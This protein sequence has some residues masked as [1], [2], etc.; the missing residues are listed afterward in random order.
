[1]LWIA[2][3]DIVW[4]LKPAFSRWRTFHWAV[5][6]LICFSIRSDKAGISSFVRAH[7]LSGKYYQRMLGLFESQ[8]IDSSRSITILRVRSFLS[9]LCFFP[10]Y[11]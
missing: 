11:V 2:W 10:S 8:G 7:M 5:V 3:F 6:T 9:K 4:K 1:M